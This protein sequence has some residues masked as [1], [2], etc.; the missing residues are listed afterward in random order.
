MTSPTARL[1]PVLAVATA[2]TLPLPALADGLTQPDPSAPLYDR[3]PEKVK[4]RGYM[5]SATT[6]RYA[7]YS[8][9]K[10]D[11][12]GLQGVAVDLSDAMSKII[13]VPIQS[14]IAE[15]VAAEI[16]GLV[17]GRFDFIFGVIADNP[18]RQQTVDMV[19]W[20]KQTT[21]F[22]VAAGNPTGI[23]GIASTCGLRVAVQKAS[24]AE[25]VLQQQSEICVSEGKPAVDIN[26]L[27]DQATMALAVQAGR[28]DASFASN[29]ALQYFISSG[30][31]LR[32]GTKDAEKGDQLD[33]ASQIV[34]SR[35]RIQLTDLCRQQVILEAWQ[36]MFDSGEYQ[37]IMADWG[38]SENVVDAP[39]I[40]LA[41]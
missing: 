1:F 32:R 8:F 29:A 37:Q 9:Q 24:F 28:I 33:I 38:L 27:P 39:G 18:S 6:G 30:N 16:T 15:S 4:E 17:S 5:I 36:I 12:S 40:N 13:G 14:E 3:L 41:K 25:P 21:S 31:A 10:A 34:G 7:P 35:A 19:D 26:V 23:D 22:L 20:T 11:G 2:F